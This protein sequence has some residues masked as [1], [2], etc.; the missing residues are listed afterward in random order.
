MVNAGAAADAAAEDG[1]DALDADAPAVDSDEQALKPRWYRR[2]PPGDLDRFQRGVWWAGHGQLFI[3]VG[4]PIVAL[5]L[6]CLTFVDSSLPMFGTLA[7]AM[8]VPFW[9]SGRMLRG[10]A[11]LLPTHEGRV[12]AFDWLERITVL[13]ISVLFIAF[14]AIAGVVAQVYV[15]I[16]VLSTWSSFAG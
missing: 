6:F 1:I 4:L 8:V 7:L 11:G 14:L 2:R 16:L 3:A 15:V 5:I 13:T 10:S 12:G 9:Y